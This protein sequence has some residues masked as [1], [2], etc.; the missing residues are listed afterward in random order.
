MSFLTYQLFLFRYFEKGALQVTSMPASDVYL[1]SELIGRAPFCKC[2]AGDM[3]PRGE[4]VIR[5]V[6]TDRSLNF[7]EEKVVI[8]KGVLTVVD[9]IF[10]PGGRS[11]T[12]IISLDPLEDKKTSQ[13]R[14]MSIPSGVEVLFNNRSVGRT[15]LLLKTVPISEHRLTLRK[16]GYKEKTTA[17]LT[18]S[19]YEVIAFMQLAV[20]VSEHVL[21]TASAIQ[22]TPEATS[23]ASPSSRVL[24]TILQ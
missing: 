11:E 12:S 4:Y 22:E 5:L 20:G 17:L 13:I 2:E 15:P 9:R 18:T 21:A 14:V 7:F 24:D 6:P 23:Q 3:I 19:G 8:Q 1:N 16:D 10:A